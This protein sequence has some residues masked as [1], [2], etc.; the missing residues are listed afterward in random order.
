VHRRQ[1]PRDGVIFA[2]LRVAIDEFRARV[3]TPSIDRRRR[4]K[5]GAF[6]SRIAAPLAKHLTE[7]GA[8]KRGRVLER[9]NRGIVFLIGNN[10]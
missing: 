7:P 5:N 1:R 2:L 3:K 8:T 6:G 9:H 4:H 10:L